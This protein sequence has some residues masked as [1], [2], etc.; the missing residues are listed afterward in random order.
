MNDELITCQGC[1]RAFV[2]SYGEQ[3]YYREHN[4]QK[5]KRCAACRQ[6]RKREIG[7]RKAQRSGSYVTHR[8]SEGQRRLLAAIGIGLAAA[9]VVFIILT[10]L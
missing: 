2:W 7:A 5:P 4:L 10:L 3:R 1:G 6:Q 8:F 9:I